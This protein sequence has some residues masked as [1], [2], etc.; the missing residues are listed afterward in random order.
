MFDRDNAVGFLLLAVCGVVATVL[1]FSIATGT[2]L[3]Y[4]GP[5]W[6]AWVL[7]ALFFG[8]IVFGMV[9]NRRGMGGDRTN[10]QPGDRQWPDPM[11]GRRRRRWWDPRTWGRG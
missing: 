8:A 3:R 9:G 2:R 7:F 5:G 10:R 6:F 4:T 11:A 1:V